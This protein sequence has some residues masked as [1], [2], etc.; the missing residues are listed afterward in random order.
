MAVIQS[1]NTSEYLYLQFYSWKI[2]FDY[3]QPFIFTCHRA[4]LFP[5]DFQLD[6]EFWADNGDYTR[7]ELYDVRL[8]IIYFLN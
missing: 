8:N 3:F 6:L 7:D 5:T 4:F 2:Y 1:L